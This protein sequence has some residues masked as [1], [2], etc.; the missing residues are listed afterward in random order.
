MWYEQQNYRELERGLEGTAAAWFQR[1]L[2]CVVLQFFFLQRNQ[3]F[4]ILHTLL[5]VNMKC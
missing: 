3:N 1:L 2:L 5:N 4:K